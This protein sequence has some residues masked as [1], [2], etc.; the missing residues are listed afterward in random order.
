MRV[1]DFKYTLK[2]NT[3]LYITAYTSDFVNGRPQWQ[4]ISYFDV[5]LIYMS[6]L[7]VL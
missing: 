6:R 4:S 7:N 1:F 3:I 2:T 5:K